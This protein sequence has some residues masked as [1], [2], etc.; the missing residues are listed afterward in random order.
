MAKTYTNN[1]NYNAMVG[2]VEAGGEYY[3]PMTDAEIKAAAEARVGETYDTYRSAAKTAH[4]AGDAA[5]AKQLENV[6]ASYDRQVDRSAANYDAALSRIDDQVQS[7]GMQRGN[8]NNALRGH[9]TG[10]G[11]EARGKIEDAR[12]FSAGNLAADRE[13]QRDFLAQRLA[14]YDADQLTDT[15]AQQAAWA[16]REFDRGAAAQAAQNALARQLYEYRHQ[17]DLEAEDRRRWEA[18]FAGKGGGRGGGGRGRTT[19]D[20]AIGNIANIGAAVGA[21]VGAGAT[22]GSAY[23]RFIG[24]LGGRP[25]GG[26]GKNTNMTR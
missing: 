16:S 15:A 7:H 3:N 18:E 12:A 11:L 10:L 9:V 2:K 19:Y 13:R 20:A 8:Y 5:L 1:K 21:V 24:S 6:L 23:D 25:S 26:S 4:E 14:Q 17:L 22:G